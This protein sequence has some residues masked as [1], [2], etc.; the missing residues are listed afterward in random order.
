MTKLSDPYMDEKGYFG[1]YQQE[2][3]VEW[4][5]VSGMMRIALCFMMLMAIM[6]VLFACSGSGRSSLAVPIAPVTTLYLSGMTLTDTT[7]INVTINSWITLREDEAKKFM[8]LQP[9]PRKHC[10]SLTIGDFVALNHTQACVL[11]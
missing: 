9:F 7:E 2:G 6:L 5:C 10:T 8:A 1:Y 3:T 11:D 4:K